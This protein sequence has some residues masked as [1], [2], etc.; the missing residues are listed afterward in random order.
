MDSAVRIDNPGGR[1]FAHS[2]RTHV[3]VASPNSSLRRSFIQPRDHFPEAK[4]C[5]FF[6][7]YAL[8]YKKGM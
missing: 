8:P 7:E 2:G 1:R 5:N 4:A 3:M 6:H